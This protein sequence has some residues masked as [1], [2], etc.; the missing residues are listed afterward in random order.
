[1]IFF[2]YYLFQGALCLPLRRI[3]NA[4]HRTIFKSAIY[5]CFALVLAF[6]DGVFCFGLGFFVVCW[7][8][9]PTTKN[10]VLMK[11]LSQLWQM[12][13]ALAASQHLF[14]RITLTQLCCG[15][16]NSRI[17]FIEFLLLW[18]RKVCC[19]YLA[20]APSKLALYFWG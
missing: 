19:W 5:F 9:F 11:L 4:I 15:Y 7:A 14:C 13:V 6:F 16:L 10:K 20:I 3:Q 2:Y 12:P 18:L 1:M 8:F 17:I